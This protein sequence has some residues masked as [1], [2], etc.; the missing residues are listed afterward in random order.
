MKRRILF[1]AAAVLLLLLAWQ[2]PTGWYDTLPRQADTPP[3]PFRGVTL[4]RVTFLVE[5]IVFLWLAISSWTWRRLDESQLVR[6]PRAAA[7]P[8]DLS[9]RNA[10]LALAVVTLL[11]IALRLYHL[12][13]DLWLDEITPV[14][15]YGPM[16]FVQVIGS[17]LRTNN[18]LLN[19]LL[20]KLS[21]GMF[22]ENESSVRLFAM[23]FGAATIPAFYWF[24][25]IVLSRWASLA[26]AAILAVSYHHIFFSQ[27]ARGYSAYLFFA[28]VSSGLMIRA[29]ADDKWWRWILYV[30]SMVLGFAALAHTAFVFVAHVIVA[31]VALLQVKRRG[32]SAWPLARRV[33]TVFGAS[34]FLSFQLYAAP[35]PEMYAVIT[36]LYVR[37][38]TGNAPVSMEFARELVR[39]LAAGFGGVVPAMIIAFIGFAGILFLQK[40][41]WLVTSTLAL[42]PMLTAM[43]LVVRGLSFS[44]RFFLLLL[45]LGILTIIALAEAGGKPRRAALVGGIVSIASLVSLVG[46]YRTPKQSYRSAIRFLEDARKPDEKVVVVYAAEGG[47]RY[48]LHRA[49]VSDTTAYEYARSVSRFDSLVSDP[50]AQTVVTTFPR[51]LHADLPDV[52]SR[53]TREWH[54]RQVFPATVG[55]GEITVWNRK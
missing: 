29:L 45:P 32:G 19:T 13:S 34:G 42:P 2:L 5:A 23:L 35:L 7:P 12:G 30:I 9:P 22:G 44:P 11:G 49:R 52:Y 33:G 1:G 39:G 24:A 26:A 4:L 15:D 20:I 48:Y 10:A 31:S 43:F 46:Y 54:P 14:V 3:L 38:A 55:D 17:Y 18:H 6:V 53:I 21:I 36:H 8:F 37:E 28:I 50:R 41:N 47:I 16:P 51:V 25:R 40:K 27:N